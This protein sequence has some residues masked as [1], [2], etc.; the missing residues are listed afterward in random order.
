MAEVLH[1]NEMGESFLETLEQG[2]KQ[3]FAGCKQIAI[4]IH[5]GEPGN[6]KALVPEDVKPITDL[7]KKLGYGFF[8]YDSSVAYNGPRHDP[9]THK[10][11]AIEKGWVTLMEK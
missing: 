7:L 1:S 2:L 3:A 6:A 10:A 5:F 8:M 9:A 11:A 4:K